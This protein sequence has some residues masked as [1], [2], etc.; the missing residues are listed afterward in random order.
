MRLPLLDLKDWRADPRG[1][2][3]ALRRASHRFGF[4]QLRHRIPDNV[5]ER[6]MSEA[7]NYFARPLEEKQL[8]G[9]ASSP[10]FRG[11]MAN[12]VENT[13]G[14][15]DLREQVEI[16]AEGAPAAA[17]AWPPYKRLS[18][19]NQWPDAQPEL[20]EAIGQYT[21]HMLSVSTEMTQ[22]LCV[23]MGLER[24]A[25]HSLFEP[26]PHWQLKLAAYQP[27]DEAQGA[28]AS[29]EA[30]IG[31][32]A[33]TDSGFLT[34]LLQDDSGGLEAFTQGEW[35][36]VP[37]LGPGVVVCNLGE[38]CQMMSGGYL[39][40]TPHRVLSTAHARLSIPF[41]YNPALEAVVP[42][43]EL[44][45]GLPWERDAEYDKGKHWTRPKNAFI[46]EY[47]ANAFK[48]L[49]R[50]HPAVFARHH[51]DLRLLEDG[52]VVRAEEG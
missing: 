4:F 18:G 41:F 43:L 25:I 47:G 40:A 9:Y 15:P 8:M 48:S 17:D 31:V 11:Y 44:P 52:R 28:A 7:R 16:A 3:E 39:L 29:S 50:S 37:P 14:K 6:A 42:R 49:A 13:A 12:G 23:A 10:A 51:A 38:V 36:E 24:G 20:E 45:P 5:A 21:R 30:R 22:A 1:F 32:G 19:P 26:T 33:H 35:T 2:A 34:M 46:A 27:A